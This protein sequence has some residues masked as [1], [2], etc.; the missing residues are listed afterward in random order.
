MIFHSKFNVNVITFFP[1]WCKELF[2]C[3][4]FVFFLFVFWRSKTPAS[5]YVTCLSV[6]VMIKGLQV[7]SALLSRNC[8]L[9]LVGEV[10]PHPVPEHGVQL[11]CRL[12]RCYPRIDDLRCEMCSEWYWV[13]CPSRCFDLKSVPTQVSQF[14][15][16]QKGWRIPSG[17]GNPNELIWKQKNG[18]H[19][20]ADANSLYPNLFSR[21]KFTAV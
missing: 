2:F 10:Q 5:P 11:S 1:F 12:P 3:P 19:W 16:G 15:L 9:G 21:M 17:P 14:L 8:L 13:T 7:A 4:L 20:M 6:K 18:S